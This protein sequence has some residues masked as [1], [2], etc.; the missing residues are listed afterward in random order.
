VAQHY[1]LAM[2][3]G[4]QR[5]GVENPELMGT[6]AVRSLAPN[7]LLL[8]NLGAVQFNYG[9]GLDQCRRVIDKLEANA[10]ILHLNPL[11]EAV[12]TQGDTNF[13]PRCRCP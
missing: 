9:Y 2:G 12:Q 1:G 13:V 10:L 4:S 8:A 3:V 7:I 6:F 5:V 11:Q